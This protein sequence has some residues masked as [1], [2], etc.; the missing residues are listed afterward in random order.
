MGITDYLCFQGDPN[1]PSGEISICA[2]L[3]R[4]MVLTSEQQSSISML[5]DIDTFDLPPETET[6]KIVKQPFVVP[7]GVYI[8]DS[9]S[10]PKYCIL[11]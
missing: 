7:N 2:D 1:V 10:L 8:E 11:R 9:F 4:P 3:S 6:D 5:A